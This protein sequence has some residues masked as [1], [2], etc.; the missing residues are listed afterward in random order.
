MEENAASVFR[1]DSEFLPLCNSVKL[2][3]VR[4]NLWTRTLS[5][6]LHNN[7]SGNSLVCF[8]MTAV[9]A[10]FMH[11]LIQLQELGLHN[12]WL[13][14]SAGLMGKCGL[15]PD[16]GSRFTSSPKHPDQ[17]WGSPSLLFSVYQELF[18]LG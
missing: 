16:R 10:V 8:A 2:Q 3:S 6:N 11:V 13:R 15:V 5:L 1:V 17:L 12:W 9:F 18:L 4:V 14:L 7:L